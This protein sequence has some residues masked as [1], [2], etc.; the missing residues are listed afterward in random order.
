MKVTKKLDFTFFD[1][2]KLIINMCVACMICVR[3]P[4]RVYSDTVTYIIPGGKYT[5]FTSNDS[6]PVRLTTRSTVEPLYNGQVGAGV[7]VHYSEVS[8]IGRV[9]VAYRQSR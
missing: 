4:Y 2:G 8:F 9:G 6:Y 3:I 5:R 1:L 7:F